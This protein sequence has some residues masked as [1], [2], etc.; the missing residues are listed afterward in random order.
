MPAARGRTQLHPRCLASRLFRTLGAYTP[1][2]PVCDAPG[3]QQVQ[4]LT[5]RAE[6]AEIMRV[7][8]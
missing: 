7:N 5:A 6:E 4:V 8:G 3:V 1:H 2:M